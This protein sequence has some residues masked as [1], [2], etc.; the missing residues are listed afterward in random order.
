MPTNMQ[1]FV[2]RPEEWDEIAKMEVV[3]ES[4]GLE[5]EDAG[6]VLAESI[7]GA[8]YNFMSAAPGYIGDAYVL[9][10]DALVAPP[11]VLTRGKDGQLEVEFPRFRG[12]PVK[13]ENVRG[14]VHGKA[15]EKEV[16]G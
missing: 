2:I 1:P 5:P 10:G 14:V 12:H 15:E 7:Y 4:W 11:L 16:H 3:R 13:H 6:D 9:T 8:R